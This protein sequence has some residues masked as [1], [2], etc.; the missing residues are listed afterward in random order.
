MSKDKASSD[1]AYIQEAE[2]M[3]GF[4]GVGTCANAGRGTVDEVQMKLMPNVEVYQQ[5]P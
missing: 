4:E 3:D 2:I 5:A 1:D